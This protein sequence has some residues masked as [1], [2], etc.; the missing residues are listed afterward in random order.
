MITLNPFSIVVISLGL[1]TVFGVMI[2][3]FIGNPIIT[4]VICSITASVMYRMITEANR[5]IDQEI[6]RTVNRVNE[7]FE[8]AM[9]NDTPERQRINNERIELIQKG[10]EDIQ[11]MIGECPQ[12]V[13]GRDLISR[14]LYPLNSFLTGFLVFGGMYFLLMFGTPLAMILVI[15]PII[16]IWYTFKTNSSFQ[17]SRN[18][19]IRACDLLLHA[20]SNAFTMEDREERRQTVRNLKR[21][22]ERCLRENQRRLRRGEAFQCLIT[23]VQSVPVQPIQQETSEGIFID[24]RDGMITRKNK[25]E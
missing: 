5:I 2:N 11:G 12:S 13:R 19:M 17:R 24:I 18:R 14:R 21:N 9:A 7:V 8:G 20:I 25:N 6:T 15:A 22:C 10:M 1:S 4:F 3:G 23:N 16:T